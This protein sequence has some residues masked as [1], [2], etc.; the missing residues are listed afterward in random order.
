LP[1]LLAESKDNKDPVNNFDT[2]SANVIGYFNY[3]VHQ[4]K[5]NISKNS[6]KKISKYFV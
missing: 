4:L 2:V 3:L 1:V 6:D 5:K